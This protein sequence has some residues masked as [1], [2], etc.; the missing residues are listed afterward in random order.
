MGLG[1]AVSKAAMQIHIISHYSARHLLTA[2]P[3][4]SRALTHST[5]QFLRQ[6]T[7]RVIPVSR[8]ESEAAGS[9]VTS[10]RSQSHWYDLL[11][12]VLCLSNA[13]PAFSGQVLCFCVLFCLF[14][15]CLLRQHFL[16]TLQVHGGAG[17]V[18]CGCSPV[19][20]GVF[21]NEERSILL[22]SLHEGVYFAEPH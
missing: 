2:E 16:C 17:L 8:V 13:A 4:T 6:I 3:Q 7:T 10:P 14:F 9:Q 15:I 18:Q 21:G 1:L 12:L 22:H 5:P 19:P 11:V 20:L